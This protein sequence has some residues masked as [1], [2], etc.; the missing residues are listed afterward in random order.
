MTPLI[1]MIAAVGNQGQ[2]G[3]DGHLPWKSSADLK[4]FKEMTMGKILIA[5][6]NTIKTLPPL[7]GR[8]LLIDNKYLTPLEFIDDTIDAFSIHSEKIEL[9]D[10]FIVIGGAK[11]YK[12]WI[13]YASRVYL[14]L[15]KGY[16]G[17][18]ADTF[19]PPLWNPITLP[20]EETT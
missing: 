11:T 9:T 12:R 2:I 15:I 3:L 16:D 7:L 20:D 10:I 18:A 14:G 17:C 4:W 13:P 6:V 1:E 8:R 19:M 5:G